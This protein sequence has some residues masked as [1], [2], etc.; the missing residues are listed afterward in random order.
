[1][2]DDLGYGDVHYNG[3]KPYTPNLDAMARGTNRIQLDRH[4][5]GAP[6]CSPTR[7]TVLTGRNHNRYCIW[8]PN[9]NWG[10]SDYAKPTTMPL[11][12]S[13]ITVANILKQHGYRTAAFGKWHVG[14]VTPYPL[15]HGHL[16][17][18]VSHPGVH[19]FDTWWMTSSTIPT[20]D[21]NYGCCHCFDIPCKKD[22]S[23]SACNNYHSVVNGSL[24]SWPEPIKG[25]DSHFIY[26]QFSEVFKET[27]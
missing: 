26:K 13:E 22:K 24:V 21:P 25:D 27:V 23:Y 19:G 4:Y 17:W 9:R 3:G 10:C 8:R 15:P 18:P 12:T 2:A 7:G 5:S 11:P 1:M 6:T 16:L 14:D 20:A